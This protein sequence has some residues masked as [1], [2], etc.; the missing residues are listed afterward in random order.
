MRSLF[1]VAVL[2]SINKLHTIILVLFIQLSV[3]FTRLHHY[4]ARILYFKYFN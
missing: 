3:F 4:N 1:F 2:L